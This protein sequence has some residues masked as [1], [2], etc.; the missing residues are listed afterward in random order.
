MM[1]HFALLQRDHDLKLGMQ[2]ERL[3]PSIFLSFRTPSKS[4]CAFNIWSSAEQRL[5]GVNRR[6][7]PSRGR[8]PAQSIVCTVDSL[9]LR[10]QAAQTKAQALLTHS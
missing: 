8:V 1:T 9:V 7:V 5:L 2:F 10:L 4:L 3:N 6:T